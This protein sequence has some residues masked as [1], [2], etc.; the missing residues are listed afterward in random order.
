MTT[1]NFGD[2]MKI[3]GIENN[4]IEYVKDK[5]QL[6]S[7]VGKKIPVAIVHPGCGWCKKTVVESFDPICKKLGENGDKCYLI[8]GTSDEGSIVLD[9]LNSKVNG[10]PNT[11]L[12]DVKLD[13]NNEPYLD[14][15]QIRGWKERPVFEETFRKHGFKI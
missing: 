11:K 1:S 15:E 3:F 4:N 14:C 8:N 9:S 12:C 6:L 10:Y 7:Q 13:E 2:I 5:Q